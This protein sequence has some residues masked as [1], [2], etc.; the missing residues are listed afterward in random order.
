MMKGNLIRKIRRF[1]FLSIII[2]PPVWLIGY[3]FYYFHM[4]RNYVTL[5]GYKTITIW[6]NYL[7][8][9]KYWY[10]FTP[11]N[12]YISV[13]N[14]VLGYDLCFTVSCDSTIGIWSDHP[15]EVHD[16]KD[17]AIIETFEENGRKRWNN[18]YSFKCVQG[19]RQDSLIMEFGYQIDYPFC[20]YQV[21]YTY[22]ND[23]GII[24]RY[25]DC[26]LSEKSHIK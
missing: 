26:L 10:P 15:L 17:F 22:R 11:K 5:E 21:E 2:V 1:L 12:N 23:E 16:L 19:S 7:I 18:R 6:G 4:K 8:F 14:T 9:D 25:Y 24:N 20:I 3:F 13:Q